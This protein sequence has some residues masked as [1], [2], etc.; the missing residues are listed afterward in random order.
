MKKR[1]RGRGGSREEGGGGEGGGGEG[2]RGKKVR[3][4][5]GG[6]CIEQKF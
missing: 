4:A 6:Q 5:M 3:V 1:T 2:K